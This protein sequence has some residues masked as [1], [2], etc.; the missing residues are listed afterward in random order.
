MAEYVVTGPCAVVH[1]GEKI[2]YLY[3][4]AV[5]PKGVAADEVERLVGRGLVAEVDAPAP[6]VGVTDVPAESSRRTPR[7]E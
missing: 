3:A 1:I 5:V 2:Q 6:I 7:K 4:G